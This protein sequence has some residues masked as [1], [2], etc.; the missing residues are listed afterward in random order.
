MNRRNNCICGWVDCP[1][2]QQFFSLHNSNI[3]MGMYRFDVGN[4]TKSKEYQEC[5]YAHLA[6]VFKEKRVF[7]ANHHW[8]PDLLFYMKENN[9]RRTSPIARSIAKKFGIC[10]KVDSVNHDGILFYAVP[11]MPRYKLHS[12]IKSSMRG[13]FDFSINCDEVLTCSKS[14]VLKRFFMKSMTWSRWIRMPQRKD[15]KS[16]NIS[17]NVRTVVSLSCL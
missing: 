15:L 6:T 3:Q 10:A 13:K 4:S 5:I 12:I 14:H 11:N 17:Q 9:K 8:N 2:L 7:I 1:E 16:S